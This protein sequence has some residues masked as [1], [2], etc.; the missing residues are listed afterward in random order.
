MR[1]VANL[2]LAL[3]LFQPGVRVTTGPKDFFPIKQLSLPATRL[4]GTASAAHFEE[5]LAAQS[6]ELSDEEFA[7]LAK[8]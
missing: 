4:P 3:P 1:Q 7:A 2:D 8:I 6:P 5:N